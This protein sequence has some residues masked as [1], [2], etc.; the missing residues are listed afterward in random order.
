VDETEGVP[1]TS[2]GAGLRPPAP[3]SVDPMGIPTRPTGAPA[4]IPV[5]DDA[6]AV[7]EARLGPAVQVPDAV[8]VVTP[9]KTAAKP[10]GELVVPMVDA[11]PVA[12]APKDA[13]GS[14]LL[15]PEQT[16]RSLAES[17]EG[18]VPGEVPGGTISVAPRGIPVGATGGG[19]PIPSGEVMPSGEGVGAP[20]T[21]LTWAIAEPGPSAMAS[22]AAIINRAISAAPMSLPRGSERRIGAGSSSDSLGINTEVGFV[23]V[24]SV[25]STLRQ[26]DA[27]ARLRRHPQSSHRH[28]SAAIA[29][30]S[31]TAQRICDLRFWHKADIDFEAEHVCFRGQSGHP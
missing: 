31:G 4:D 7:G 26:I 19:A 15:K 22:I 17:P 14:E 16:A 28:P 20:P 25:G 9:S 8:P 3:S 10:V 5:G 12:G 29:G 27:T 2:S 30:I 18:V 21:V 11:A 1:V 24:A 13:C 23:A 6:D